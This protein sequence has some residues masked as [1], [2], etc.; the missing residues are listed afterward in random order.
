MNTLKLISD[1]LYI[2]WEYCNKKYK[3]GSSKLN[4]DLDVRIQDNIFLLIMPDYVEYVNSG[5]K[6]G[7]KMPPVEA[8]ANWCRSKGI[9][10]DNQTIW[11]IRKSIAE[12]GIKMIE[13]AKNE[14][15][16]SEKVKYPEDGKCVI[17]TLDRLDK[18]SDIENGIENGKYNKT[19]SFVTVKRVA[20][21]YQYSVRLI[22]QLSN[23]KLYGISNASESSLNSETKK[24]FL[25]EIKEDYIVD[26][27]S[28][29]TL[30]DAKNALASDNVGGCTKD[31]LTGFYN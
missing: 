2:F 6:A 24:N 28:A 18:N 10:S 23:G 15:I 8:I 14:F 25:G 27:S 17:F 13:N 22:E 21:S 11:K 30:D 5:R 20:K 1:E 7:A 3:L 19:K 12:D 9:P 16:V 26:F 4:K 29:K 31:I